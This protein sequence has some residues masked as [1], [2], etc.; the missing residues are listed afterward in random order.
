MIVKRFVHEQT[1]KPGCGWVGCLISLDCPPHLPTPVVRPLFLMMMECI[2]KFDRQIETVHV[3]NLTKLVF[4]NGQSLT[5]HM[6]CVSVYIWFKRKSLISEKFIQFKRKSL[7]SEKVCSWTDLKARAWVGGL[8]FLG[9]YPPPMVRTL[10]L[11]MIDCIFKFDGQIDT[12]H[13]CNRTTCI[14]SPMFVHE[15]TLTDFCYISEHTYVSI[16]I[17][18]KITK[19][20]KVKSQK[21]KLYCNGPSECKKLDIFWELRQK[22]SYH[23]WDMDNEKE[24]QLQEGH[25]KCKLNYMKFKYE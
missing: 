3:C 11:I 7:I 19:Y 14:R 2:F 5:L 6:T 24:D 21:L 25:A 13:V 4:F 8:N 23:F 1:L 12:V 22:L 15:Q 9:S 20:L 16:C 10:F 17:W 18:W